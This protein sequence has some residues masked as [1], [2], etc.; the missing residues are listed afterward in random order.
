MRLL[1]FILLFSV[2]GLFSNLASAAWT[3]PGKVVYVNLWLGGFTYMIEGQT[4]PSDTCPGSGSPHFFVSG[5]T[6]DPTS[7]QWYAMVMY[8]FSS[9]DYIAADVT[10]DAYNRKSVG[11]MDMRK[12]P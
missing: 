9:G 6:S 11:N 7:R 1:N 8:A 2:F 12:A 4:G 3:T 10:C 5:G